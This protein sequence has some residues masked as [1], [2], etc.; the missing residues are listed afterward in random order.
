MH[1]YQLSRELGG[2]ARRLLA[3]LLRLALPDAAPPGARRRGG[4]VFD[5][6][7][8]RP[9]QDTST[10]S[11]RRARSCSSSSCRRRRTTADRGR[12]LPRAA[13]LLQVPAARDAH[14]AAGAAP[15]RYLEERLGTIEASLAHDARRGR[16][17]H[18]RADGTR[19]GGHRAGHRLARRPDPAER[20]TRTAPRRRPRTRASASDTAA[21]R[22][23]R[24]ER[25]T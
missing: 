24:K 2:A 18:A 15:A 6:G 22:L 1:G 13:R 9:P 20:D 12:P 5:A 17:L 21:R 4:D 19:P 16:R 11:P 3:G 8:R 7:R 10:A 25:T 23:R 14:P